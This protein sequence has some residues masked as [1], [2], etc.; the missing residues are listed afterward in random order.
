MISV[1]G[2]QRAGAT[3]FSMINILCCVS[4]RLLGIVCLS[5]Q[6]NNRTQN[7]LSISSDNFPSLLFHSVITRDIE[8]LSSLASSERNDISF[9]L[10]EL[11]KMQISKV[12]MNTSADLS[13]LFFLYS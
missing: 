3:K 1:N 6:R 7:S 9:G 5:D 11:A 8:G 10:Q 13:A 2:R 4:I 12:L